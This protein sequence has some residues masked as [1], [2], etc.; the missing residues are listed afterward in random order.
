MFLF[1]AT[2]QQFNID[3]CHLSL[4]HVSQICFNCIVAKKCTYPNLRSTYLTRMNKD[5][6][7]AVLCKRALHPVWF[8]I[9]RILEI[10]AFCRIPNA[11]FISMKGRDLR[12]GLTGSRTHNY[13]FTYSGSVY[14]CCLIYYVNSLSVE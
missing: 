6:N 2:C 11:T 8:I 5:E 7:S 12:I 1:P 10:K 14:M 9:F 3:F 13:L 4:S